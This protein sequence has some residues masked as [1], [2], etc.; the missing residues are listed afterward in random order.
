M[1]V[2]DYGVVQRNFVGNYKI[3]L[4]HYEDKEDEEF[5]ESEEKYFSDDPKKEIEVKEV[6]IDNH[7]KRDQLIVALAN[8]N[9][10][11]NK[12]II[13][14]CNNYGLPYSKIENI[15]DDIETVKSRPKDSM[16]KYEFC[17]HVISARRFL[18]LKNEITSKTPDYLNMFKHLLPLLLFERMGVYEV[19]KKGKDDIDFLIKPVTY[20]VQYVAFFQFLYNNSFAKTDYAKNLSIILGIF[21]QFKGYMS[22]EAKAVDVQKHWEKINEFLGLAGKAIRCKDVVIDS[23]FDIIINEEI[24]L[25]DKLKKS[26]YDLAPIVF[27]DWVNEGLMNVHPC[28]DLND[29][30]E[31]SSHFDLRYQFDGIYMELLLMCSSGDQMCK[32]KNTSCDKFFISE[33]RYKK[34]Y[35]CRECSVAAAK[36]RQR[37]R[38]KENPDRVREKAQFQSRK[39]EKQS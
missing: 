31:F 32:C 33:T 37:Q 15:K 26:M 25:S 27:K 30:R 34:K 16:S 21:L 18:N 19:V 29:K 1:L 3:V 12:S 24:K 4:R 14:F 2:Y 22:I 10:N 5:I 17:R 11:K 13:E 36:R 28:L 20:T 9:I 7:K 8:V 6:Q 39:T 35:C 23:Y 38:D